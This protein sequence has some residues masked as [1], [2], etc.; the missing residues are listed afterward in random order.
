LMV[1]RLNP[2]AL[3]LTSLR[4]I[5][6]NG[7]SLVQIPG[8]VPTLLF[9]LTLAFIGPWSFAIALRSA[10]RRGTLSQY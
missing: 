4:G 6:V 1:A 9:V 5:F 8:I 7:C 10:R 2:F 3:L